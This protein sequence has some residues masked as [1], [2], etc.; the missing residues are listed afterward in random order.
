MVTPATRSRRTISGMA[1]DALALCVFAI[2]ALIYLH[3]LLA[4]GFTNFSVGGNESSDPQIFIWGLAWYP[5]AL[6]HGLDP[7]YTTLAFAPTGYNLAWSTT[8]PAPALALWPITL[9]FGPLVSFNLLCVLVPILSGYAAFALCRQVS[10]A[11][12]PSIAGGLVYGF[13]TY[14]RIE[15]DHLNLGLS[16]IPPLLV[17]LFLLRMEGRIVGLRF[18]FLLAA[19]LSFQFLISPEIF[20][21]SILFGAAAIILSAW[22]GEGSFRARL[23][24]PVRDSLAAIAAAIVV[25]SPYIYRFI[26]SPFGLSPIYNPAHCSSDLLG[27]LIP[28]EASLAGRLKVAR[29]LGSRV[30]FGCEPAAYMG[31]LPLIAIWSALKPRTSATANTFPIERYLALLT[32]G[33]IVFSLGPII[34]VSGT[35]VAPS[36]WLPALMIPIVNNALPARFVLYAFLTLSVITTLWLSGAR[37]H[38]ATRWILAAAAFASVLPAAVPAA[39]A[40]LPFF[41]QRIYRQYLAAGDTVMFL[42]FGYNGQAMKWQAQSGFFFSVAGGYLSVIPHEYAAW[43]IVGAMLAEQPYIPGFGDQFKAF[44]A[45]HGVSAVVVP[46]SEYTPYAKLCA[47]LAVAPVR[48]GGVII[49]RPSPASLAPFSKV[50][51]AEMD[52][53]Y[54]LKRFEILLSAARNYLASGYPAIELS[55]SAAAR[56]RLLDTTIAGDP[57]R[58]QTTGFPFMSAARHSA[59]FQAIARFLI[60]HRMIRERLAVELGPVPPADHATTSGIW[61]GPWSDGMIAIGVVASPQAAASLRAHFGTNADAIYYPYPLPYTAQPDSARSPQTSS[62]SSPQPSSPRE[63]QMPPQMLLMTFKPAA[64]RTAQ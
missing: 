36:L 8:I 19:C 51:A 18:G 47:T 10:K 11:P 22:L 53:R 40:T 63:S 32:A 1:W 57:A 28:T 35:A 9:Q 55:P 5:Y 13:S 37:R 45:A 29:L 16:F 33:T 42:P 15:A 39:N 34:H 6:T 23:R 38:A 62:R 3:P 56:M 52:A 49:F 44:M 7:L 27:F 4:G 61:L 14:Q 25:L 26:P 50:T 46:E 2:G 20:A 31:L 21:T 58:S 12:L 17:L 64:L 60:S 59:A 43:P 48:A 24:I 54:N 41:N 30:G